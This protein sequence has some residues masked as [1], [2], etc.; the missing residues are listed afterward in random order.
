MYFGLKMF[1]W[2]DQ[3]RETFLT[4]STHFALCVHACIFNVKEGFWTCLSIW[5]VC[6]KVEI[7][8]RKVD[9]D[10]GHILQFLSFL[11]RKVFPA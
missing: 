3:S 9:K 6:S 7:R 2:A 8:D 5:L 1:V 11:E 10:F 4:G